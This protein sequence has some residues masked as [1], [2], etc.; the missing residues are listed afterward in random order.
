MKYYKRLNT[1]RKIYFWLFLIGGSIELTAGIFY[2]DFIMA[3][4]G[5]VVFAECIA[6]CTDQVKDD[7][8]NGYEKMVEQL[9]EALEK[10]LNLITELKKQEEE[11]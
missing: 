9:H 11:K 5:L 10:S 1:K 8:I 3:M 4:F 6:L 2:R 7:I